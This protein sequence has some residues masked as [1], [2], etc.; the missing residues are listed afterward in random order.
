MQLADLVVLVTFFE[1]DETYNAV[2][3]SCITVG[4][5]DEGKLLVIISRTLRSHS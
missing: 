5:L 4:Q 3:I 2:N 1:T